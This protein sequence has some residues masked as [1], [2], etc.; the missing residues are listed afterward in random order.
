MAKD[1]V[2]KLITPVFRLS[3]PALFQMQSGPDGGNPRYGCCA[4]WRPADFTAPEKKL[5]AAMLA[6]L[7]EI[8]RERFKKPWKELP[9]T[10][11]R[12]IRP[13]TDKE[14][15]NGF[16]EGTYFASLT[17]K[18]RPGVMD[19]KRELV[20]PEHDNAELMFP[21]CYCRATVNPY[22]YDNIGK[23]VALGL[24]SIQ[25]VNGNAERLDNIA[26]PLDDLPDDLG[27]MD[28]PADDPLGID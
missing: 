26:N 5:W 23:G 14:G 27:G 25:R 21:G 11:K 20:G 24:R 4:I 2:V 15:W 18:M 3:F 19:E 17:S 22:S 12:G 13:G 9:S 16:G 28:D 7:D 1:K 8:S 10:F 6:A